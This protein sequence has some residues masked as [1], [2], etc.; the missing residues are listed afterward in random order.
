MNDGWNN[1]EAP[2]SNW[3]DDVAPPADNWNTKEPTT[4]EV[5][6]ITSEPKDEEDIGHK[7]FVGNLSF[8]TTEDELANLKANIITRG[9]R[10]LGYGFVAF[11]TLEDAQKATQELD[12]KE[13]GAREINVE[14]A[15]PKEPSAAREGGPR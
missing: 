15:K 12:K 7:V 4:T 14:V 9:T 6:N 10:S 13:L 5:V 2:K 11:E 3:N 1:E 8:Q